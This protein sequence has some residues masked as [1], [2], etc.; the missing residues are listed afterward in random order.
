MTDHRC[1]RR[2]AREKVVSLSNGTEAPFT[3]IKTKMC[4]LDF[5]KEDHFQRT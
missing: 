1:Q 2:N 5:V 4:L 3:L